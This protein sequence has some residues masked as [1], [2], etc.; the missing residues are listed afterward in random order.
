MRPN[1]QRQ[2][3]VLGCKQETSCG[4]VIIPDSHLNVCFFLTLMP[5]CQSFQSNVIVNK[6]QKMDTYLKKKKK[7]SQLELTDRHAFYVLI[8]LFISLR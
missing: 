4:E 1:A 2:P 8:G 3:C 6:N 5:N 7:K